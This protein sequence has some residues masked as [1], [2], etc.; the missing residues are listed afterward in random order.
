MLRMKILL[1]LAGIVVVAVTV[2]VFVFAT[3]K[4][5]TSARQRAADKAATAGSFQKVE[6]PPIPTFTKPAR[7]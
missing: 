2:V 3:P 6:E 4:E 7:Q 1:P 5:D